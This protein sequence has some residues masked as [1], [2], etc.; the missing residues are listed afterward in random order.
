MYEDLIAFRAR[1]RHEEIR[2]FAARQ[3]LLR[4]ARVPRRPL[5]L[6][7][8]TLLVRAGQWL[9]RRAPEWAERRA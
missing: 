4:A 6:V 8:G 7:V 3:A 1:E 2:A 5:T 9:V